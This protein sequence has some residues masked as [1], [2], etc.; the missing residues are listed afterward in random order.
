MLVFDEPHKT[1]SVYFRGR[2]LCL[3]SLLPIHMRGSTILADWG[4]TNTTQVLAAITPGQ[5]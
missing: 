1:Y 3:K 2:F 5:N 4:L